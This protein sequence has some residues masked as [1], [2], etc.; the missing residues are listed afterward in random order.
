MGPS[1]R[2]REGLSSRETIGRGASSLMLPTPVGRSAIE[3]GWRVMLVPVWLR[4]KA[5]STHAAGA[6]GALP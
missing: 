6:H 5:D 1:E 4:K 2:A 3:I